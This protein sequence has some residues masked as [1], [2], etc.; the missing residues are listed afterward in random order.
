MVF[1]FQSSVSLMPTSFRSRSRGTGWDG[2]MDGATRDD[3]AVVAEASPVEAAAP[4]DLFSSRQLA[5]ELLVKPAL[6]IHNTCRAPC[7]VAE[8]TQPREHRRR[9]RA[10]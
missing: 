5:C 8:T 3:L 9:S 10:T 7:P 4:R 1:A 6:H 2:V